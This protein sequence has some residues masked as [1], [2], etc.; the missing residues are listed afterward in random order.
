MLKILNL[1]A[2]NLHR[3][4][5]TSLKL[6]NVSKEHLKLIENSIKKIRIYDEIDLFPADLDW[7]HLLS[8]SNIQNISENIKVRKGNGD[9]IGLVLFYLNS[10]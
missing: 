3:H 10:K 5:S 4:F 9:I 1:G 6:N 8:T 2:K 7:N